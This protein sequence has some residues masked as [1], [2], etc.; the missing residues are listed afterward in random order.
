MLKKIINKKIIIKNSVQRIQKTVQRKDQAMS[1]SHTVNSCPKPNYW[2]NCVNCLVTSFDGSGHTAPC[3]DIDSPSIH[4]GSIYAQSP[5]PVLKCRI[6]QKHSLHIFDKGSGIFN[7][8]NTL[9]LQSAAVEGLFN[10][11][12]VKGAYV[13][14]VLSTS[15]KRF[16]IIFAFFSDVELFSPK[17]PSCFVLSALSYNEASGSNLHSA[18]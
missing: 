13:V 18:R 11:K 3:R 8:A 4:R 5:V 12:I 15:F 6:D 9:D 16:S 17:T 10:V 1:M 7:R 2:S 14:T